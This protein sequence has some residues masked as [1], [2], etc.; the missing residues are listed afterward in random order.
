[1]KWLEITFF[2][3]YLTWLEKAGM[4]DIAGYW[5]KIAGMAEKNLDI[6]RK[7]RTYL[8]IAG[9]TEIDWK[10]LESARMAEHG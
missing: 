9:M 7:R 5:L 6:F 1:M 3:F 8:E 2:F 4:L 10:M